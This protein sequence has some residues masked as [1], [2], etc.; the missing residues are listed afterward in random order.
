MCVNNVRWTEVLPTVLLSLRNSYKEDLKSTAAE[1]VYGTALRLPG[2]LLHAST[3]E[4][5]QSEFAEQLSRVMSEIRPVPAS[6]H[7]TQKVFVNPDLNVATRVFVRIDKVRPPLTAPYDGPYEV[8][9]RHE[10]YFV[11]KIKGYEERISLDRLKPAFLPQETQ[12]REE[13]SYSKPIQ[14][15]AQEVSTNLRKFVRFTNSL[16]GE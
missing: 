15:G 10:K 1:L 11:L 12:V 4:T 5:H 6:N 8:V 14:M 3:N 16:E 2:E 7:A 9:R 13:H